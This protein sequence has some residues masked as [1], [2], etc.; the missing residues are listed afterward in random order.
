MFSNKV[1][2]SFLLYELKKDLIHS[3]ILVKKDLTEESVLDDLG[4]ALNFSNSFAKYSS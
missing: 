1:S 4:F 3:K 2:S